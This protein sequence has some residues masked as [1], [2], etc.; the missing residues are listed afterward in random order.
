[1]S[2]LAKLRAKA[3]A[4]RKF[5]PNDMG[6]TC[7]SGMSYTVKKRFVVSLVEDEK[8]VYHLLSYSKAD[9]SF[10]IVKTLGPG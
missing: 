5:D 9:N 8:N 7:T 2:V 4:V 1:M 10:E 6:F 3:A